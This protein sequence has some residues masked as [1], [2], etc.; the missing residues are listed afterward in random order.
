MLRETRKRLEE[1]NKKKVQE[2]EK[3]KVQERQE[4][5]VEEERE[6]LARSQRRTGGVFIPFEESE[7]MPRT[8]PEK[9]HDIGKSYRRPINVLQWCDK[10]WDD[11]AIKVCAYFP[12]FDLGIEII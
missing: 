5:Q 8:S 1:C 4:K 2:R 12:P 10:N 9:H 11:P 3:K 7:P 6:R